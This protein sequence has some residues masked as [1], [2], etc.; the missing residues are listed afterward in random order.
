MQPGWNIEVFSTCEAGVSSA[1]DPELIPSNQLAW[2]RNGRIRGGKQHTRP[3]LRERLVLPDGL[4]QGG[5]YFSVQGGMLVMQIAGRIYRIRIGNRDTD[6]SSEEIPL[7]FINSPVLPTAWMVETVGSLVIQDG[8]SNA[9]IYDG[10]TARRSDPAENEVPLGRMMAYGNGRLWVAVGSNELEAGDI[11]TNQFQSELKFTETQYLSGGGKFLFPSAITGLKFLPAS[12]AAGYGSLAAFLLEQTYMIR[13]EVTSRD[14][15]AQMPGF[16][17]ALLLSTGAIG[18]YGISEV[19][20]DLYWRDGDGGIRSLRSAIADETGGPGLTPMSR[21]VSRITDFESVHRLVNCSSINFGNRL[22]VTASPFINQYGK[23]SFRDLISLDFS[24][25]SSMRGKSAPSYDGEWDGL[26]FDLLLT[27]KFNGTKRG[28]AVS[29]DYDGKNR[30]WEIVDPPNQ[31][32]DHFY[33]CF[34]TSVGFESVVPMI[35]EYPT[36]AWNTPSERKRLQ[37]CDVYLTD[38]EGDCELEVYYRPDNYQK[39]T[40]WGDTISFCA[41]VTDPEGSSP[42]VWKNLLGQERP[43]VKTLTIDEDINN[44]TDFAKQVGFQFQIRT[45]LRGKAR[46]HQ[47]N[48][49][50]QVINQTQFADRDID[51]ALCRENDVTGNEINYLI[52]PGCTMPV[53]T[54]LCDLSENLVP[55]FDGDWSVQSYPEGVDPEAIV[56]TGG[57][58]SYNLSVSVPEF[59]DYVFRLSSD[60]RTVDYPVSFESCAFEYEL[61][62]TG[63]SGSSIFMWVMTGATSRELVA[64]FAEG[65]YTPGDIIPITSKFLLSPLAEQPGVERRIFFTFEVEDGGFSYEAPT[66]TTVSNETGTFSQ[67]EVEGV[68]PYEELDGWLGDVSD[69]EIVVIDDYSADG[70]YALF[71]VE[72]VS[73]ALSP[74]EIEGLQCWWDASNVPEGYSNG[75]AMPSWTDISGRSITLTQPFASRYPTFLTNIQNGLPA[76]R[77]S[78]ASFQN[79]FVGGAPGFSLTQQSVFVVGKVNSLAFPAGFASSLFT[80]S[81]SGAISFEGDQATSSIILSSY[82]SGVQFYRD[83][84]SVPSGD[85]GTMSPHIYEETRNA[86]ISSG[87]GIAFYMGVYNEA[88]VGGALDCDIYEAFIFDHILTPEEHAGLM[89]Y[90][91]EKWGIAVSP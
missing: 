86:V 89:A 40:K 32:A 75:A 3:F 9:I 23:T 46:I 88:N 77:F 51:D 8:Q 62:T 44:L 48:V 49:Y 27:G 39:W 1:L 19:N 52:T 20:Q 59:G 21:E 47:M 87:G 35:T 68:D 81:Q 33:G 78:R 38:I 5:S 65:T 69:V 17:Q 70:N 18:Q 11:V 79:L 7:D 72:Q 83:G 29:T 76:V 26:L 24:P 43:Q 57:T 53:G 91:S 36:R 14:L 56:L 54:S 6:F 55:L 37:R 25:V 74:D 22:L 10:S 60:E 50:A 73:P 42:H 4:V 13:A 67:D 31:E 85:M 2:M 41:Q 28:F 66:I 71:S 90:L 63:L 34:G 84:T 61:D 30:L 58:A 80:S 64:I 45:V 12:G 82:G 16:I 15:W